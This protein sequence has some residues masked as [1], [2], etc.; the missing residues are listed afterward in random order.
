MLT[1]FTESESH[2]TVKRVVKSSPKK[3]LST[4]LKLYFPVI[5]LGFE[6]LDMG[7]RVIVS[8]ADL[9]SVEVC[10]IGCLSKY[11]MKAGR[12]K[13]DFC[14]KTLSINEEK[15]SSLKRAFVGQSS[16]FLF[17][18]WE[19]KRFKLLLAPH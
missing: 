1:T 6:T 12:L 14:F 9:S 10:F 16:S 18:K 13:H 7:H 15:R 8:F 11:N 5:S 19:K 17:H 3:L 2:F 4:Y